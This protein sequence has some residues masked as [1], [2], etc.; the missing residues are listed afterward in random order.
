MVGSYVPDL[1]DIV[2]ISL[3]PQIGHEQSGRRPFLVLS[4]KAYNAKTSLAVGVPVTSRSK[5]YPFEVSLPASA[6]V[7]GVVLADRIRSVDWSLRRADFAGKVPPG[8]LRR[9]RAMIATFLELA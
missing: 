8:T 9:V 7:T 2:W 6:T 4:R 5:E 1:G 3:D